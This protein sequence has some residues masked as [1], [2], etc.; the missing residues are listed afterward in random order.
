[1][2]ETMSV[3]EIFAVIIRK[4]VA[5][6]CLALVFAILLGGWQFMTLW[7][8]TQDPNNSPA[9]IEA[10]YQKAMDA[11]LEGKAELEEKLEKAQVK[12]ERQQVYMENSIQMHIDPYNVGRCSIMVSISGLQLN[13]DVP[14]DQADRMIEKVQKMYQQ[15]WNLADLYTEMDKRNCATAEE[16]YMREVMD[17]EI[18]AG[19]T[20]TI[21]AVSNDLDLATRQAYAI[22]D[23]LMD[24]KPMI[25]KSTCAHELVMLDST[26]KRLVLEGIENRQ[27]T[28]EK[29]TNTCITN[30]E[31]LQKQISELKEPQKEASYG[32]AQILSGSIKWAVIGGVLGVFLGCVWALCRALLSS[33]LQ[34]KRHMEAVLQVPF[35]GSA[36]GKGNIFQRMAG[37]LLGEPRWKDPEEAYNFVARNIDTAVDKE[38]KL[39]ILTT[40]SEKKFAAASKDLLLAAETACE[41]VQ[42][43]HCADR[44]AQA[45]S[46]LAE[47]KKVLLAERIDASDGQRVLSV[48]E[49]A[50]RMDAA[51]VGFVTV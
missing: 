27:T 51:V 43:I 34:S 2:K 42:C 31:K 28:E 4:G 12:L 10:R 37:R 45:I 11:Y 41:G 25:E 24:M 44:N 19:G 7:E 38:E 17:I 32:R 15:Y 6:I 14:W 8:K 29:L 26:S 20:L 49:L 13:S 35:M 3:Q 21:K 48:M 9:E 1:M 46:T 30:V 39:L 5:L 33:R 47:C 22:Y 16:K 23:I 50:K 36:A 18:T 40:L